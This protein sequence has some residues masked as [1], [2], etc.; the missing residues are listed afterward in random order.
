[1]KIVAFL[2]MLVL[3]IEATPRPQCQFKDSF[4]F[5]KHRQG[6][7]HTK[8]SD[9]QAIEDMKAEIIFKTELSR[10]M[11]RKISAMFMDFAKFKKEMNEE[12]MRNPRALYLQEDEEE[13]SGSGDLGESIEE[14]AQ[15]I[16]D[17]FQGSAQEIIDLFNEIVGGI[18]NVLEENLPP[19]AWNAMCVA[20]WWPLHEEHCQ[21]ARCATC[22]PAVMAAVSVCKHFQK[23]GVTHK[24]AQFVMGEGFCNYCIAGLLE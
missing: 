22:S 8:M 19:S 5:W 20:T 10:F 24:C 23:N 15:E 2:A 16:I 21:E 12:N 13:G 17:I 9:V 14:I 4:P 6:D 7:L 11:N 3:A 18:G 1:M